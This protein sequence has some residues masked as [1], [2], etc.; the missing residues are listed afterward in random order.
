MVKVAGPVWGSDAGLLS[1]LFP[2]AR[3]NNELT[4]KVIYL[5][6]PFFMFF[7]EITPEFLD[8][9]LFWKDRF[10]GKQQA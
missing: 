2:A 6:I 3:V 7:E 5:R 9:Q 8:S 1:G 4:M 10:S